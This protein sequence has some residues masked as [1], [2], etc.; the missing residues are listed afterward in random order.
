[1][2]DTKN[3][4]AYMP[5][6]EHGILEAISKRLNMSKSMVIRHLVIY[7]GLCGGDMPLTSQILALP[8]D[9][10]A[11]IIAE[12][13]RKAEDQEASIPQK[14]RQ[15]VK[16]VLGSAGPA[17]QASGASLLIKKLLGGDSSS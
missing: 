16:E 2:I 11:K 17:E 12:I 1:M 15:W 6:D 14:F 9:K 10:R 3:V 4:T 8:P 13:R 5:E 7:Q